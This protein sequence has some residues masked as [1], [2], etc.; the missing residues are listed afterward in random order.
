MKRSKE[1]FDALLGQARSEAAPPVDVTARVVESI[2][3]REIVRLSDRPTL[4]IVMA[5]VTAASVAL[6]VAWHSR[7][8][9]QNPLVEIFRPPSYVVLR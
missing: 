8:Q 1:D 3:T 6:G 4:A 7:Q 2:R 5:A 9:L